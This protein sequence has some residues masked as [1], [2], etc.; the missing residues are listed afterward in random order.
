MTARNAEEIIPGHQNSVLYSTRKR[1]EMIKSTSFDDCQKCP[2][3]IPE[4]QNTELYSTL[5]RAEMTKSTSFDDC[6]KFPGNRP[7]TQK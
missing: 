6:Q 4:H 5:K 7:R 3:I 1:L 2:Q